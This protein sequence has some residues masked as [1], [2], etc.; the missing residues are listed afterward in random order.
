MKL[1]LCVA[2]LNPSDS[3]S[4]FNKEK[5]IHLTHFYPHKFS[6]V[7]LVVLGNQLDMYIF[8]IHNDDEFSGIEGTYAYQIIITS[9][10]CNC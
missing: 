9:I 8:Y 4:A 1:L 7:D 2:C 10:R 6:I 5:L 3:F